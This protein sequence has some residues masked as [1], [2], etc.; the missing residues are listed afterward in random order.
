MTIEGNN[1]NKLKTNTMTNLALLQSLKTDLERIAK[2]ELTMEVICE[3][4]YIYCSEL[5]SLRLLKAY[6]NAEHARCGYSENLKTH[7]FVLENVI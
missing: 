6:R 7:Y 1:N 5:T 2:E 3:C 4:V